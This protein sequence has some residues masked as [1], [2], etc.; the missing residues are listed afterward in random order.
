VLLL[1]GCRGPAQDSA[2]HAGSVTA[3]QRRQS[4]ALVQRGLR[5]LADDLGREALE[6]LEQAHR[7]D[8]DSAAASLALAQ[9][10]RR[11]DRFAAA[12][13]L[14]LELS[15]SKAVAPEDAWRAREALAGLLLDAGNLPAARQAC[16]ELLKSGRASA[17]AL[18]LSGV[19]AYRDG[20][21]QRAVADLREAARL[22][23]QDAAVFAALG[24]ALLQSGDLPAA[25]EALERAEALEPNAQAPVGNLAKVYERLGRHADAQAA[26]GRFQALY[27]RKSSRRGLDPLRAKAI[28]AYEAGRL[29]EALQTFRRMLEIAPRD[30]QTLAQTGSVLLAMRRLDEARQSLEASLSIQ[31]ENDFALMELA[32]VQALREDL[33]AAIELLQ[34]AARVNPRAPEPHYFLAGIYLSQG[35]QKEFEA[36]RDAYQRLQSSAGGAPLAPLPGGGPP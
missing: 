30:P 13:T 3:E 16:E 34:R 35:R 8:P 26:M 6:A 19:I 15:E 9:A 33:P 32:R 28:E 10:Y 12:R 17:T 21:L 27:Q 22:A 20:N 23:P 18:R 31:P 5:F 36:E 25:A 1:P 14:L 24:L 2:G 4:A 11:E 29:E 7:L